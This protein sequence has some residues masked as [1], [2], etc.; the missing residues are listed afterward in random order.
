VTVM[1]TSTRDWPGLSLQERDR[2]WRLT[3]ELIERHD[4]D[5]LLVYGERDT[6]GQPL[7]AP[8]A[9]LTNDRP[10]N[11]VVVPRGEAP[12]VMVNLHIAVGQHMEGVKRGDQMWIPPERM[13]AGSERERPGAGR[14]ATAIAAFL[15]EKGLDDG[16]IGVVGLEPFG[17]SFPDGVMPYGTFGGLVETLVGATFVP[18][19][20]DWHRMVI[21]RSDE[22]MTLL[23]VSA[24]AG[25]AMC[26]ALIDATRP[27]VG[28][29][30]LYA[31]AM[32]ACFEAGVTQHWMILVTARD[33]ESVA[34]GPPAWTYRPQAPDVVREGDVVMAELFPVYGMLESQQQLAVAVG[35]VHPDVLRAGEVAR[36][37]YDAGLAALRPGATFGAVDD[38]MNAPVRAAGGW[39]LTPHI[40]SMNPMMVVGTCGLAPE[41]PDVGAYGNV[42]GVSTIGGDVELAPGMSFAFEPNCVFGRRRVNIGGTVVLTESGPRELNVLANQL[43][44]V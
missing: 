39:T 4:L 2:R 1:S 26:Q 19:G 22:E 17:A 34:W 35:E 9:W 13:Y 38:A 37:A 21:A 43:H 33:G 29:H 3:Q 44:R 12:Y 20:R 15:R 30:E 7:F 28:E 41:L 40:H 25:E 27:D 23:E 32:K 36:E 24:A 11:A 16:R 6:V 5:A 18:I 14:S 31:A 8:D 42:G 10:G